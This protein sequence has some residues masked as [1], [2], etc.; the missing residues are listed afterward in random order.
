VDDFKDKVVFVTGGGSGIGQGLAVAFAE[1]GARIAV[2]DVNGESA[3]AT[4]DRLAGEGVPA[5]GL[6]LDVSD[7][8]AWK[9]AVDAAEAALGPVDVLCNSAGVSGALLPLDEIPMARY[10]KLFDITLFGAIHGAQCVLPRMRG[11]G[12]H[13]VFVA[14][15]AG[16]D[17]VA[18]ISDYSA[19]KAGVVSLCE[20]MALEL[21]GQGIGV[22]VVCPGRVA[23]H[24]GE[25]SARVMGDAPRSGPTPARTSNDMA[26]IEVGRIVRE[27][28]RR[29]QLYIF[30]H[31]ENR[32]R[33][34]A[35]LDQILSSFDPI[36]G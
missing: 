6:T 25:T 34:A 12:G 11:R 23:T 14:S 31:P 13:L 18:T 32:P 3:R 16:I 29:G 8:E 2:S 9:R 26:P 19:A 7:P 20:C 28:V 5:I 21:E 24:L 1:A 33:V 22:S 36:M 30:T 4:A 27:A 15:M 17:P 10:R 35:R